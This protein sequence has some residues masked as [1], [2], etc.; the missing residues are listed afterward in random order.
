MDDG[1]DVVQCMWLDISGLK[2]GKVGEREGEGFG[3]EGTEGK[4]GVSNMGGCS[5]RLCWYLTKNNYGDFLYKKIYIGRN[6]FIINLRRQWRCDLIVYKYEMMMMRW[7][8]MRWDVSVVVYLSNKKKEKIPSSVIWRIK[9]HMKLGR[10]IFSI[11][12]HTYIN[13]IFICCILN[14]FLIVEIHNG[15]FRKCIK[16]N[17]SFYHKRSFTFIYIYIYYYCLR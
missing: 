6:F 7:D 14:L 5:G 10:G 8:E 13:L 1:S 2:R 15:H 12:T 17:Y 4:R 16:F 9:G 11:K 3:W